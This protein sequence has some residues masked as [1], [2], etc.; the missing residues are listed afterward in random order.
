MRRARGYTHEE[1]KRC[2][3]RLRDHAA[4]R[5]GTS[6]TRRYKRREDEHRTQFECASK[7]TVAQPFRAACAAVGRPEGLRYEGPR[8]TP[9]RQWRAE[10]R[11]QLAA[12]R[13]CPPPSA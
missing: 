3:R 5:A 4:M 13:G 1:H 6:K 8:V 11:N 7:I 9:T 10:R 2:H 12:A